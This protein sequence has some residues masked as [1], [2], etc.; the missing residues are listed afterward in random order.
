MSEVTLE[1]EIINMLNSINPYRYYPY[2]LDD[3][4]DLEK[5]IGD[6]HYFLTPSTE[7][8]VYD[9]VDEMIQA[10]PLASRLL[11]PSKYI[12]NYREKIP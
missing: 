3:I 7:E 8:Y 10:T 12:R 11:S 2:T 1:Q 6:I 4:E 9:R 5:C